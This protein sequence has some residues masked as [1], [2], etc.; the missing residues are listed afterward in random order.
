MK[1]PKLI[2]HRGAS[3]I[4]PEN[5]LSSFKKAKFL[6]ASMVEFDVMLTADKIPVVIHDENIKRTTD[7]R[8][9]VNSFTFDELQKFDAGK[10]FSKKFQGE[11]IPSFQSVLE[12]IDAY[13]LTAN[14]EI[15]P[16]QGEEPETVAVVMS[17]MNQYW[18]EDNMPLLISSFNYNVLE[19]V[20]N[21]SPEQPLG[22]LMDKWDE[23]WL[24]KVNEL[25]C[26]SVHLNQRYVTQARVDALKK[27]A[28]RVLAYTVNKESKAKKLFAMGVDGIFSDYADLLP[29]ETKDL[30]LDVN[31]C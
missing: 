28:L 11:T 30:L 8:G 18:P 23:N 21:F 25:N 15:K 19:M 9:L 5:T 12:L 27:E 29:H 6:G 7:G 10:W 24:L 14:V 26:T 20:R 2:A 16:C 22:L 17:Y 1:F 13:D 3:S 31:E 4:A